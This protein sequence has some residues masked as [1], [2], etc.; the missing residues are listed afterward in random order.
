MGDNTSVKRRMIQRYGAQCFIEKLKIRNTSNIKYKS[1]AQR[2][3]MKALTYHHIKRRSKGG[4]ATIENGAL[5]SA[6]NH[7]WFN[8]QSPEAQKIMNNMFQQYKRKVDGKIFDGVKVE[9]DDIPQMPYTINVAIIDIKEM[10]RRKI[11]K[12]RKASKKILQRLKKE[13]EDR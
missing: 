2:K 3:R 10:R 5:L 6:E 12:E 11:R 1:K 7:I 13:W 8:K 4:R 9:F